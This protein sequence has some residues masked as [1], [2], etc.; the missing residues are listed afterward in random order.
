MFFFPQ[1]TRIFHRKPK[2]GHSIHCYNTAQLSDTSTLAMD[3]ASNRGLAAEN[4]LG[5][6]SSPFAPHF[7][8]EEAR[9]RGSEHARMHLH[10]RQSGDVA[11]DD[12]SVHA[13]GSYSSDDWEAALREEMSWS[14]VQHRSDASSSDTSVTHRAGSVVMISDSRSHSLTFEYEFEE[15]LVDEFDRHEKQSARSSDAEEGGVEGG[16]HWVMNGA[17]N[18]LELMSTTIPPSVTITNDGT[19]DESDEA[20][21]EPEEAEEQR[22]EQGKQRAPVALAPPNNIYL[23]DDRAMPPS[24]DALQL[25]R[26]H[27]LKSRIW[28]SRA[29]RAAEM[30]KATEHHRMFGGDCYSNWTRKRKK[31]AWKHRWLVVKENCVAYYRSPL[32]DTPLGVILFDN[33]FDVEERDHKGVRQLIISNMMRRSIFLSIKWRAP[34]PWRSHMMH[35]LDASPYSR[36]K[37]YGSTMPVRR[38]CYVRML[39]DGMHGFECMALAMAAARAEIMLCSWWLVLDLPLIRGDTQVNPPSSMRNLLLNAAGRGVKVYIMVYQEV[40]VL[41]N[42]SLRVE[43]MFAGVPNV[44]VMRHPPPQ[45]GVFFWSHH[46]KVLIVDREVAFV[47]GLD[48]T[49]NRWDTS[50][51]YIWSPD[52]ALYYPGSSRR[53]LLLESD[54]SLDSSLR[55]L[56][57]TGIDY[58]N[59]RIQ[60]YLANHVAN[61]LQDII[62]RE[63]YP[64]LPWHDVH[65]AAYGALNDAA[66][67]FR[68]AVTVGFPSLQAPSWTTL[69]IISSRGGISRGETTELNTATSPCCFPRRKEND[70][71]ATT[72]WSSRLNSVA[73]TS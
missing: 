48:F 44:L 60:D 21:A 6:L 69:C 14:S 12:G 72:T 68:P 26:E 58:R 42:D 51:H 9:Q 33:E 5:P 37:R 46:E 73:T 56:C 19:L 8:E 50:S 27:E 59:P 11:S 34:T 40:P 35:A 18:K 41:V 62:D 43:Q 57:F 24:R 38:P 25:A 63:A 3:A 23:Q 47:G 13:E 15:L 55:I 67:H 29:E 30:A 53:A 32:S 1:K 71:D 28:T 70:C 36:Q 65:C 49:Y 22:T 7:G 4:G 39:V 66:T 16:A 52:S 64:R 31:L 2:A 10:W 17:T 20:E 54:D 61:P 45:D